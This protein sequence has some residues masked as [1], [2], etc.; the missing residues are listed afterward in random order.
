MLPGAFKQPWW[1]EQKARLIRSNGSFP[2]TIASVEHGL[3]QVLHPRTITMTEMN[4][5]TIGLRAKE[6]SIFITRPNKLRRDITVVLEP[7]SWLATVTNEL[8]RHAVINPCEIWNHAQPVRLLQD[9]CKPKSK[10]IGA[11]GIGL[12]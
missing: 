6:L 5:G 1:F 8:V 11:L 9:A 7:G 12:Y 3:E 10:G 2:I 4:K